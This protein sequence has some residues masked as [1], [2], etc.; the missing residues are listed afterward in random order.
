MGLKLQPN[1]M[2]V[3]SKASPG[4][5]ATH[6]EPSL[7]HRHNTMWGAQAP[8]RL[9]IQRSVSDPNIQQ[10][11]LGVGMEATEAEDSFLPEEGALDDLCTLPTSPH[12]FHMLSEGMGY[13][14]SSPMLNSLPFDQS[15]PIDKIHRFLASQ[16]HIHQ[17]DDDQGIENMCTSDS[18]SGYSSPIL[19]PPDEEQI[20]THLY[21]FA[22]EIHEESRQRPTTNDELE[23]KNVCGEDPSGGRQSSP[24]KAPPKLEPR[25]KDSSL[26]PPPPCIS[27]DPSERPQ[28]VASPDCS[29]SSHLPTKAARSVSIPHNTPS[30][31][32]YLCKGTS[33]SP[34]SSKTSLSS[35]AQE[36]PNSRSGSVAENRAPLLR[37]ENMYSP[38]NDNR[39]SSVRS[40]SP[41]EPPK[42]L[43]NQH[44]RAK[45]DSC[46]ISGPVKTAQIHSVPERVKE[47]EE[48]HAQATKSQPSSQPHTLE[49]PAEFFIG[50]GS[51]SPKPDATRPSSVGSM[52]RT[53]SEES[54]PSR[55][56][57][58]LSSHDEEQEEDVPS[59][60]KPSTSPRISSVRHT[61]LSPTPFMAKPLSSH[62]PLQSSMS[63]PHN[64]PPPESDP[65]LSGQDTQSLSDEDIA[66]SLQG[67]VKARI[68]DIEERNK[69][70]VT[71]KGRKGS[72]TTSEK[73]EGVSKQTAPV[74]DPR[75]SGDT[76]VPRPSS[77]VIDS[78]TKISPFDPIA[79]RFSRRPSSDIDRPGS[80]M[81][82]FSRTRERTPSSSLRSIANTSKF[83]SVEDLSSHSSQMASVQELKRRFEDTD[84]T[85]TS[86]SLRSG[87]NLRRSQ[88]L[89]GIS[90]SRIK[91][92]PR[93][94]PS[95]Q[96]GHMESVQN[97]A[98]QSEY[99]TTLPSF[100]TDTA[101]PHDF[102]TTRSKFDTLTAITN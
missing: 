98:P 2:S 27:T 32:G 78:N 33:V 70:D 94:P 1:T 35:L 82:A 74:S 48:M 76:T 12:N 26:S 21:R 45:S 11:L 100:Q 28:L 23:S 57:S 50:S 15:T 53:S 34:N 61:S 69:E 42:L 91:I 60:M 88:S 95:L 6:L 5:I 101:R 3:L 79:P 25:G 40:E 44:R 75:S 9:L 20:H 80:M 64:I 55:P 99:I 102:E 81:D 49:R 7:S 89:R 62:L 65:T 39:I 8:S 72:Q 86:R 47:I 63:L 18:G 14:W 41:S 90:C 54:L 37:E 51:G 67:A 73:S 30:I 17:P 38:S 92:R 87:E 68:Q 19:T 4:D 77:M 97:S 56:S 66:T 83:M 84:E 46:E 36:G 22:K 29:T 13:T 85:G 71:T 24:P 16:Q 43:W 52:S 31:G 58:Q 96:M 10:S 93:I 59:N